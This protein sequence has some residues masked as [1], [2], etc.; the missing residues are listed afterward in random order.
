MPRTKK[1]PVS[2][3]KTE[4]TKVKKTEVK[5]TTELT[6]PVYDVKGEE[7]KSL[8]LPKEIFKSKINNSLLAQAIRVYQFNQRQGT[9]STKTRSEVKGST[10]KI[11]RQKGTGRARHGDIKAPI[12]VGGGVAFGPKP[13]DY[14]LKINKK[15]K[16][17]A[18]FSALSLQYQQKNIFL[19]DD[20]VLNI[21]A[22]TKSAAKLLEKLNI[23]G[24]KVLFV[25]P[26][27]EKNSFIL[28]TRNIKEVGFIDAYSINVFEILNAHKLVFFESSLEVLKKHF[29][30]N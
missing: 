21:E 16:R 19:F 2:K 29:L 20:K 3:E 22:K 4:K 1:T 14:S 28:A 25:L 30:K 5:K 15:Q 18:I 6:L 17:Q 7:V 10:R 12:F 11:Y 24:K 9:A 23:F 13:R 8:E 27:M 26:K